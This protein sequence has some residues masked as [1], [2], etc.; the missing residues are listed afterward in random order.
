MAE[1]KERVKIS[2]A[3][4]QQQWREEQGRRFAPVVDPSN[5]FTMSVL[6]NFLVEIPANTYTGEHRSSVETI[7]YVLSGTGYSVVAGQRHEWSA[8]DFLVIPPFTW[9]QHFNLHPAEAAR[10]LA[11]TTRPLVKHL[12]IDVRESRAPAGRNP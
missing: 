12:G 11:T 3:D 2:A 1:G 8:G 5:G 4:V 6:Q 10:Y 9:Y 7:V